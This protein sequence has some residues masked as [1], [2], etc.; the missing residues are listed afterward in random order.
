MSLQSTSTSVNSS[1]SDLRRQLVR[2]LPVS[3]AGLLIAWLSGGLPPATWRL[4]LQTVLQFHT[5]WARQGSALLAPFSVLIV[6]S[7]FLLIAWIWFASI[8]VR[9]FSTL[10]AIVLQSRQI[11]PVRLLDSLTS[12]HINASTTSALHPS[13]EI[14]EKGFFARAPRAPSGAAAPAPR[15]FPQGWRTTISTQKISAGAKHIWQLFSSILQALLAHLVQKVKSHAWLPP[16]HKGQSGMRA[17]HG[18]LPKISTSADEEVLSASPEQPPMSEN[19][20]LLTQ[21]PAYKEWLENPFLDQLDHMPVVCQ[22]AFDGSP[23]SAVGGKETWG[24]APFPVPRTGAHPS[25]GA[26]A[27]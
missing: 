26:G 6:Q 7:L 21:E 19:T 3:G 12:I 25:Q 8:A 1:V 20:L 11:R 18:T 9:E 14:L 5:I 13:G 2:C 17:N 24:A 15:F 22:T 27:P 16:Q 10:L 23:P 4:L